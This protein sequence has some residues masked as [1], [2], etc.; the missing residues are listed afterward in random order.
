MLFIKF[1]NISIKINNEVLK[2]K[3]NIETHVCNYDII[4]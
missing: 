1:P 2:S 3:I 4:V